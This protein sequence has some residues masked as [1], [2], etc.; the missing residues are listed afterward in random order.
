MIKKAGRDG[1]GEGLVSLGKTRGDVVVLCADLTG[2]VKA[3]AFKKEFPERFVSMGI[4]ES[5]MI[6][7][8]AGLALAG[9]IPFAATFS[10]FAMGRVW[11]QLR[12]SVCYNNLNV[13]ICGLHGGFSASTDGATH[14]GIEEV[15]LARALPNMKVIVPCDAVQ[16]RKATI[17]AAGIPGPVL[18]NLGKTPFPV[19]TEENSPF[20]FGKAEVMGGGK[21]VTI[22]A[23]GAMVYESLMARDM[24]GK[25]GISARVI[26]MH[27]I[28]PMDEKEIINSAADTGAIVTA[29]E[30]L[31]SGGLGSAVCEV[32][33]RNCPVPVEMMGINDRF[34]ESGN[35]EELLKRFHL[36]DADIVEAACRAIERKKT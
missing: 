31:L 17:A 7:T 3:S 34:G 28:K 2:S 11:D 15:S 5:D 8:A 6:G 9:K 29:E 1:F 14:Q 16:T 36:K 10:V 12:I 26:N 24:L 27:T 19:I 18:I 21:D 25:K 33:S 35:H 13:K 22:I 32:V 4:A 30:H 23:C 20:E